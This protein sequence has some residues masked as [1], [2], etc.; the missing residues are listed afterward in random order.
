MTGA[1]T[2]VL[3]METLIKCTI[4]FCFVF[5]IVGVE[6]RAL[7]MPGMHSYHLSYAPKILKNFVFETGCYYSCSGWPRTPDSSASAS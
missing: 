3:Q 7:L 6:S 1:V 2:D 4:F 5:V